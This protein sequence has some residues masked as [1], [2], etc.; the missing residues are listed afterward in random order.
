MG[1]TFYLRS[2]EGDNDAAELTLTFS[3]EVS[4][5]ARYA[6]RAISPVHLSVYHVGTVDQSKRLKLGLFN[7]HHTVDP[8]L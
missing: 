1:I 4:F 6:E 8:S 5:S 7:F 2:L 3:S